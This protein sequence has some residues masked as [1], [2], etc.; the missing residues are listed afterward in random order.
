[1]RRNLFPKKKKYPQLSFSSSLSRTC[2]CAKSPKQKTK[3]EE[4]K[5]TKKYESYYFDPYKQTP[6]Y[7]NVDKERKIENIYRD[8]K[9]KKVLERIFENEQ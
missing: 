9:V 8:S 7:A 5:E 4:K 2:M 6:S 3:R 1:M